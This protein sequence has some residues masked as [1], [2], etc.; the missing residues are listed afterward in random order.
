MSFFFPRW[1]QYEK[2]FFFVVVVV[3]WTELL[4]VFS[5]FSC[6][7]GV[8]VI[9]CGCVLF[10]LIVTLGVTLGGVFCPTNIV[11][12]LEEIFLLLLKHKLFGFVCYYN[13]C[14]VYFCKYNILCFSRYNIF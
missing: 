6:F 3:V 5:C 14:T 9:I 11:K 2:Y 13:R 12:V 1:Y 7:L 4:F 8:M 10:L